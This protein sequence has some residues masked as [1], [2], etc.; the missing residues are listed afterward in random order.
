MGHIK[1]RRKFSSILNKLGVAP[2]VFKSNSNRIVAID[3]H[4]FSRTRVN[5]EDL[6]V[7]LSVLDKQLKIISTQ[8]NAQET[9]YA[10]NM[11]KKEEH[12]SDRPCVIISIDDADQTVSEAVPYFVKYRIPLILFVPVGLCLGI[13]QL[14]GLRSKCFSLYHESNNISKSL[15]E[16]ANKN[17]FF[18]KIMSLN[19]TNLK[20]LYYELMNLPRDISVILQRNL[21]S[22]SKIQS[23]NENPLIT[24]SSHSMSHCV[25]ADLPESWMNW[26]IY[27]SNKYIKELNGNTEIFAYPY[28]YKKS[29]NELTKSLLKKNGVKY[30]F[31]TSS[32][33]LTPSTQNYNLGRISMLNFMDKSY[34]MGTAGGAF[35]YWD[36][37][38]GR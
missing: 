6:E 37:I 18:E 8:C 25:M 23:L 22:L 12:N 33:V 19:Y 14:D 17:I 38:L 1:T 29:Y 34:V 7:A 2:P 20:S 11:L 27:Q 31:S 26:E 5:L 13:G 3:Y 36:R 24:I 4:Y 30:A 10:L 15:P 16:F 28:G 35:E 21:L 9:L 32:R